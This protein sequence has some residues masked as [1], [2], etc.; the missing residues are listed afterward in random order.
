VNSGLYT[1]IQDHVLRIRKAIGDQRDQGKA[2]GYI[3]IPISTLEGSY[4]GSGSVWML[5]TGAKEWGLAKTATGADYMLM[6]TR[7]LEGIDGTGSDFDFIYFVGPSD[8]ARHFNLDG[9]S[10]MQKLEAE[11]DR[12]AATEPA[13]RDVDKKQFR[14]YYALRASIAFSLGSH[15]EWNIVRSIN[16]RRRAADKSYGIAKQLGVL[17]DGGQVAPALYETP[18]ATGNVGACQS[19]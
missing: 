5:N 8:F 19:K 18:V 6:W 2:I 11:Y 16:E 14:N 10:D 1:T 7:V 13:I 4:F 3:S 9:K 17:F 15:D 12:R